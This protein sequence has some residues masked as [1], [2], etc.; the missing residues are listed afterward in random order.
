M[1]KKTTMATAIGT[2]LIACISALTFSVPAINALTS[3]NGGQMLSHPQSG[4]HPNAGSL[5]LGLRV[6]SFL[7][8]L[9]H[10]RPWI[11]MH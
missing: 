2:I 4:G 8:N 5:V 3:V 10:A 1:R 7:D 9:I 6:L 11:H